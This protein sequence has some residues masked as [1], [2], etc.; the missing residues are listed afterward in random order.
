MPS[1]REEGQIYLHLF[2]QYHT[3]DR[4]MRYV[5]LTVIYYLQNATELKIQDA[6]QSLESTKKNGSKRSIQPAWRESYWRTSMQLTR[7]Q[8]HCGTSVESADKVEE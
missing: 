5:D 4:I 1:R 6:F 3:M 8:K 2:T 7:S